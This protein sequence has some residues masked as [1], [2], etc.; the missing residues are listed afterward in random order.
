MDNVSRGGDISNDHPISIRRHLS[1]ICI[2]TKTALEV[3]SHR[4]D[5]I[6]ETPREK[7][8]QRFFFDGIDVTGNNPTVHSGFQSAPSVLSNTA[9]APEPVFYDTAVIAE[10]AFDCRVLKRLIKI[11]VHNWIS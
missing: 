1:N 6:R 2:L 4:S 8:I 9:Y 5:G 7:M 10:I 11:R 3:A